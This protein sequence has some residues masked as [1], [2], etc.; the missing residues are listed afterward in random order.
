MYRTVLAEEKKLAQFG[1]RSLIVK[2][3]TKQNTDSHPKFKNAD[4]AGDP[5]VDVLVFNDEE[6]KDEGLT[7]IASIV[8]KGIDLLK[9]RL[10]EGF[11]W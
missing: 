4:H 11:E 1:A 5:N 7:L 8:K 3:K 9:N 2:Q 6:D 10:P